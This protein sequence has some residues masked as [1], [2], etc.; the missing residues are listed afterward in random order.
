M[1][2]ESQAVDKV[3][4]AVKTLIKGWPIYSV[5][6]TLMWSYGNFFL[7]DKIA[8]AISRQTLEVPAVV[9]LGETV[10][11]NKVAHADA[12]VDRARIESKVE[13]IQGDTKAIMLHLA[14]E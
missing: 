10:K 2:D 1:S 6:A 4:E 11:S 12:K 8:D 3:A 9:V 14:G 7:D 13:V 5:V